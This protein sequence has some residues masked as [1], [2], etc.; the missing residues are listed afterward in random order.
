MCQSS[1]HRQFTRL[2]AYGF[3]IVRS[4][5]LHAPA[6]CRIRLI[7]GKSTGFLAG[8][9]ICFGAALGPEALPSR[10]FTFGSMNPETVAQIHQSFCCNAVLA[11]GRAV[12]RFFV[13]SILCYAHKIDITFSG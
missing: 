11:F 3:A 13:I 5:A 6:A 4:S 7:L 10:G 1:L 9:N 2:Y 8:L 12:E